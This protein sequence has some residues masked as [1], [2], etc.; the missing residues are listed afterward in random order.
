MSR[1]ATSRVPNVVNQPGVIAL[2]FD[3]L[4][5]SGS[6]TPP[7]TS[8]R[9]FQRAAADRRDEGRRGRGDAGHRADALADALVGR[10]PSAGG[11]SRPLRVDVDEQ[12]AVAVEAEVHV[13]ERAN[14]RMNSPAATTSTSDSATCA[15]TSLLADADTSRSLERA[16]AVLLDRFHRRDA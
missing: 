16:A 6:C 15:T 9:L 5:R 13:R 4:W 11:I 12:H 7:D 2:K 3:T 1:P 8:T 14:V 10:Q